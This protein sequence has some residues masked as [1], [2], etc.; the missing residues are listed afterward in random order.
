MM[1]NTRNLSWL[2]FSTVIL[3]SA[4]AVAQQ[5][6]DPGSTGS[7]AGQ[8][9]QT[10][11]EAVFD[12]REQFVPPSQLPIQDTYVKQELTLSEGQVRD[13]LTG[14]AVTPDGKVE[15]IPPGD[16]TVKNLI[17]RVRQLN[18]RGELPSVRTLLGAE[19]PGA[20]GQT[21]GTEA[22]QGANEDAGAFAQPSVRAESVI[23]ADT[24]VQV[25]NTTAFP[26]RTVGRIDIGCSGTLIGPRHVLTAG[27]CVYNI[28]NN[29]W[30]S[31]LAFSPGQN[32]TTRPY[33]K[34][35]W[36]RAIAVKGWTQDHQRNY[37]YAMIILSS[38]IGQTTGWMGYGWKNPLPKYNINIDG[39]PG[40]K[41][42]GTMW[43]AFCGI[44]IVQTY[45][46]YYACD[47][48]GGMS[49]SKVHY[50]NSSDQ[51]RIIYGIHAYGVDST[52]LNGATRITEAVFNNLKSWKAKY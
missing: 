7:G 52:G 23:G 41:P 19:E 12:N 51:S 21:G 1:P 13:Q 11:R 20:A 27:H 5:G 22:Q 44:D 2:A 46:L 17:E 15:L 9:N 39:Y 14:V 49:G 45:R 33:G 3:F 36:S 25:T 48:F 24:R 31:Q 32:G 38:D 29:Q 50:F 47:T 10:Q 26:F 28:D 40:D 8:P 4:P 30:Y 6:T 34:I 42:S 43:H 35:G 16:E 18:Q 37:D